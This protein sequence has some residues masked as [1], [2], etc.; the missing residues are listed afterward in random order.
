MGSVQE[1]KRVNGALT[2]SAVWETTY[3]CKRSANISK[4]HDTPY[5]EAEQIL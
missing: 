1:A 2:Y 5:V 4:E 3:L